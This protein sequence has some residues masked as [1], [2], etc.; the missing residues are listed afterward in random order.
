MVQVDNDYT[1]RDFSASVKALNPSMLEGGVTGIF[2]GSYLQSV[3]PGLA[4]GLE[5]MW[6][7]PAM[8]AGPESVVSY[9]AKYRGGDWI[10][11]AQ[12]QAMGAL[13]TSYWRRLS[14]RVEA[15]AEL[16]LQLQPGMGGRG[17]GGGL[18]GGRVQREGVATVGAKYDFRTA[19]F[20]AQ[21][22]SMGKLSVLMEKRVLQAIQVIFAGEVDQL[23]V[24]QSVCISISCA[25]IP[26]IYPSCRPP[27]YPPPPT[28]CPKKLVADMFLQQQAKVGV[29]VSIEVPNE[30]IMEQQEKALSAGVPQPPY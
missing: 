13:S 10:A 24:R 18:M 28:P 25:F 21:A 17:G 11:S 15:G 8:S 23:K 14:D 3:T 9:V 16:S 12:L 29:G 30:E 4:L 19:S 20:K 22:D 6:Q 2:I 7:R 27:I 5:A 1:G 26:S